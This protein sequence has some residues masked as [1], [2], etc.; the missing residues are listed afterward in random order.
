VAERLEPT[1][2]QTTDFQPWKNSPA[3]E[4][5]EPNRAPPESGQHGYLSSARRAAIDAAAATQDSAGTG[6]RWTRWHWLLG[7]AIVAAAGLGFVLNLRSDVAAPVQAASQ[8]VAHNNRQPPNRPTEKPSVT[9]LAKAGNAK[10]QLILGLKLLNGAGVAMNI[11]KAAGWLERAAIRGQPVAQETIGVLY[12]TGTGVI[13]NMPRAIRWYEAAAQRGNVKAMANLAKVHA[14]GGSERMDFS[15]A[16]QWFARAAG[17]GDVDAEFDLAILYERGEGVPHSPAVAYKWYAIAAAQGDHD[18][19]TQAR[20][21]AEQL[22]PDELEAAK[23]AV[24]DFKPSPANRAAN[25]IPSLAAPG[26]A[27]S[28]K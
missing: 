18:A 24:A 25:D 2:S 15:K 14:G 5:A 4:T 19:A 3:S 22:S 6:K 21:V 1:V 16:A 27:D 12:Q 7:A 10:A 11:E 8:P 23:Q 20:L 17:F 26:A 13:A 9:A 28:T